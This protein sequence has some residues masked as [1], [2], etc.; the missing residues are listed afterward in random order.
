LLS[1][2][3][4]GGLL[5][6]RGALVSEPPALVEESVWTAPQEPEIEVLD[7]PLTST[8]TIAEYIVFRATIEAI[9][10]RLPLA[11]AKAESD[12]IADAKNPLSTASGVFQF[13][14]STFQAECIKE[15]GLATSTDDKNNPRVQT[16]CAVAMLAEGGVAHWAASETIWRGSLLPD[17]GG[18]TLAADSGQK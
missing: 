16:D 18:I 8:T 13:L 11:I 6:S 17:T 2:T 15:R 7:P 3:P 12:F 14:D 5:V 4:F 1:L 10:P 9:D